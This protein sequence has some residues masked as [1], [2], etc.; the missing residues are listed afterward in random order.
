MATASS[1]A[2]DA[3]GFE[4]ITYEA[5]LPLADVFSAIDTHFA[6]RLDLRR[7]SSQLNDRAAQFRVIQKRL[8]ARFKDRNPAPLNHMDTLLAETHRGIVALADAYAAGQEK[9]V[10]AGNVLT[11]VLHLLHLLICLKLDLPEE[12]AATLAAHMALRVHDGGDPGSLHA[13]AQGWEERADAG[14]SH[15]LRTALAKNSKEASAVIA[16]LD[17]P[18]STDKL[19]RHLAILCDRLKKG[20]LAAP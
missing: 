5:P 16:G 2:R 7:T 3:Q 10:Q 1:A 6:A 12:E 9:V 8:L 13:Q 17:M 14:V 19:K 4:T 15:L 18:P 20:A 11:C